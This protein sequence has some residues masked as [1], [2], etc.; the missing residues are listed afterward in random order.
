MM[1]AGRAA[2]KAR[3]ENRAMKVLLLEKNPAVGKKLLITGGGRC[4]L[5]NDEPD[6]R[7]LLEKFKDSGKFL[8]SAFSKFSVKESLE[9][10]NSRGMPTKEENDRRVFP[11]SNDAESVRKVLTKYL[12][13]GHVTVA[14]VVVQFTIDAK[15]VLS[16]I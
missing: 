11:V 6:N 5:T 1:A 15:L 14:P 16:T 7:V 12:E 10:F 4:N 8:F 3:Q 13:D 2:E 9:F